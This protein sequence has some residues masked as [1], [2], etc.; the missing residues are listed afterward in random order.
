MGCLSVLMAQEEPVLEQFY[1]N[2]K[3]PYFSIGFL[4]Q[5]VADYQQERI[6]SGNNGFNVSSFRLKLYGELDG[7]F[8]Y[9]FQ[10]NFIK[11]PAILDA[12]IYYKISP[13]VAVDAGVFK[14]PFS[15]EYLVSAA[16]IDFVNRAQAVSA[17][18]TGRQIGVQFRSTLIK[19]KLSLNMGAFNGNGFDGNNN[20]NN[21]LLYAGR[22]EY[23]NDIQLANKKVHI[24]TGVNGATSKDKN[25]SLLGGALTNFAG[26]RQL[27][28]ADIRLTSD[29]Y[30]LSAEYLK[31]K[32]EPDA[33][34]E[35]NSKGFHVTAG[36]MISKKSQI[37]AR[38]DSF[39]SGFR[40]GKTD[41]IILGY[42]LWPT[43][44][45]EVQLN[46]IINSDKTEFKYHQILIN[47]QIS[48]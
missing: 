6:F 46:Y 24:K 25:I 28:G 45:S 7:G 23:Q 19:S 29:A 18:N 5:T 2:F 14:A 38:W 39:D 30:L 27:W 32:Y 22:L 1:Q 40:S 21:D 42:N 10:T 9:Y 4:Q 34:A 15:S 37:L 33:P 44:V 31:G 8:G 20:D 36:V 26:K 11:S 12:R 16:D 17:M 13:F 35:I 3:K 48:V 43:K 47:F 41:L